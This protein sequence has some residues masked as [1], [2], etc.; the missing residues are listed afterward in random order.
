[1]TTAIPKPNEPLPTGDSK[2]DAV[3]SMFD[4]IAPRYDF[5]NRLMT[6]GL[7]VL[8]RKKTMRLL[9]LKPGSLVADLACGTGDFCREIRHGG[10]VPVGFDLAFGMLAAARTDAQLVHADALAL[11]L[12]DDA[13]D[14]VTCG[15]ALRN[16]VDLPSFLGELGRIV[17]PGGRIGLLDVGQP[18]LP[19]V[20]QGYDFYF[21]RVVP[22]I[23]GLFSDAD[24]YEYL[25]RSVAYLPAAAELQAMIRDAG[26]DDVSHANLTLGLSQ[27]YTATRR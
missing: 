27:V 15:F 8:W 24:A 1:M 11:P 5:V 18:S 12:V 4:A 26:F 3:Q 7:D 19:L 17:K 6:F 21:G 10:H 20:S 2:R 14:A 22:K 23:G 25:P 9:D 13:V 16:F